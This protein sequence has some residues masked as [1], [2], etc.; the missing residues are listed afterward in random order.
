MR[1]TPEILDEIRSLV[2]VSRVAGR[3]VSLVR[4]GREWKGL[5]PFQHERTPSFCVNDRKRFYHC[6][7]SGRHGDVFTFL[8]E[9]EGL[10]FP[11]AVEALAAEAGIDL[12]PGPAEGH[13]GRSR[14]R[15]LLDALEAAGTFFRA[16]LA[17]EE[18]D[19]ARSFLDRRGIDHAARARFGIG[20][21][22]AGLNDLRDHLNGLGFDDGT[23]SDAGLVGTGPAEL[24][25]FDRFRDRIT[26][27]ITDAMGRT[28]GFG[29]R[30]LSDGRGAKYLNSPDTPVFRKGQVLY[31]FAAARTSAASLGPLVVVE[32]YLDVVALD[33]A[34]RRR[35]VSTMG[36]A[37]TREQL[38]LA[39]RLDDEPILCFDGDA[40]GLRAAHRAMD[41]ALEA[42]EP[43]RSVRIAR[44][45]EQQDPDALVQ[46]GRIDDF[47][48]ALCEAEPLVDA[49]WR[50][51]TAGRAG[52]TPERAAAVEASLRSTLSRIRHSVVRRHYEIE[53][54]RRLGGTARFATGD[55]VLTDPVEA[56]LVAIMEAHPDM[57]ASHR[58]A[59]RRVGLMTAE[60]ALPV[61]DPAS[62]PAEDEWASGAG[63]DASLVEALIVEFLR[64][65]GRRA[66]ARAEEVLDAAFRPGMPP[67]PARARPSRWQT[68]LAG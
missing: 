68:K 11:E 60:G 38:A 65:L 39:W 36:T 20:Y 10:T 9:T 22:P 32:G 57:R 45:P 21:A 49:L 18:G 46:A 27:P 67:M 48:A 33:G 61:Y 51:E 31:N 3:R 14:R 53:I 13:V 8:M 50:R 2:P 55:A 5:S 54:E 15:E 47:D 43:G 24:S 37:L 23:L 52:D 30:A 6:F 44:L 58:N 56:S 62:V 28:I 16:R 12:P 25:E 29:A 63:A 19:D 34:D 1:F 35:T 66:V 26:L 7:S 4:A 17:D 59:L 40:A 41:V 42:L 64:I